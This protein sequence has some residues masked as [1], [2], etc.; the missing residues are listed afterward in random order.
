MNQGN[1]LQNNHSTFFHYRIYHSLLSHSQV[2]W[3]AIQPSLTFPELRKEFEF[4]AAPVYAI[5]GRNISH[6]NTAIAFSSLPHTKRRN[7][8][9]YLPQS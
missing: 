7:D 1:L 9:Q 5:E 6:V 2:N 4:S 3:K 8:I